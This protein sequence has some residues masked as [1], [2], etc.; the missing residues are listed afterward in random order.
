M[1]A[2]SNPEAFGR[3]KE[4]EQKALEIVKELKTVS[5][6]AVDIELALVVAV[7]ELHKGD[8]PPATISKIINEHCGEIQRFY[9]MMN[10]ANAQPTGGTNLPVS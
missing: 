6:N 5:S 2:P 1:S 9:D 3:Y 4:V 8:L 10:E 7:Y